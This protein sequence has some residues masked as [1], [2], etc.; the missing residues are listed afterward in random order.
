MKHIQVV[1]VPG[2]CLSFG[3][4]EYYGRRWCLSIGPWLVFLWQMSDE[5]LERWHA[6]LTPRR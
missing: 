4:A 1:R 6:R 2:W 5:A 3:G